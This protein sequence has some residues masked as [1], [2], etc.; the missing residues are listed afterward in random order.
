MRVAGTNPEGNGRKYQSVYPPVEPEARS[1]AIGGG[2]ENA[3]G[4]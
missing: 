1:V 3:Y 4:E 2:T